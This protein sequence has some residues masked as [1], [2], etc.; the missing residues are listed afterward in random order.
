[1]YEKKQVLKQENTT[2]YDSQLTNDYVS[3]YPKIHVSYVCF[4]NLQFVSETQYEVLIKRH[5][6]KKKDR[7]SLL[8][9]KIKE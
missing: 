7:R 2:E 9:N 6:V 1:M 5:K 8:T 4:S 3:K